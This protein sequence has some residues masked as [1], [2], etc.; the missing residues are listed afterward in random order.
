MPKKGQTLNTGDGVGCD[1]IPHPAAL[2]RWEG[3]LGA[4]AIPA[5]EECFAVMYPFTK[6]I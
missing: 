5:P 6:I 1:S 3:E 4:D 2:V